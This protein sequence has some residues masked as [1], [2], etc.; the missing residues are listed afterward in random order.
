MCSCPSAWGTE[1]L[2][3]EGRGQPEGPQEM[4]GRPPQAGPG[5]TSAEPE[6]CVLQW[7]SGGEREQVKAG[8]TAAQLAGRSRAKVWKQGRGW[9]GGSR[10][11]GRM[12]AYG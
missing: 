10:G 12:Y 6:R 5:R 2:G 11:R 8:K 7:A 4:E 3:Q 9:E 1:S